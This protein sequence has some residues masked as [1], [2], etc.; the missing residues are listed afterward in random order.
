MVKAGAKLGGSGVL[1]GQVSTS[2]AATISPGESP[3]NM[4]FGG[5]SMLSGTYF[6]ELGALTTAGP[7]TNF[8]LITVNTNASQVGGTSQVLL[9]FNL[10]AP[11]SQPGNGDA[12]WNAPHQ[13][14]IFDVAGTASSTGIFGSIANATFS[15]GNFSLSGGDGDIFLGF[16]PV[17]AAQAP[18]PGAMAMWSLMSLAGLPFCY[19]RYCR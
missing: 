8:D 2:G 15:Q 3:A 5:F 14:L 19:R 1:P 11:A 7:G 4:V 16:T 18:E 12:F 17:A 6:W 10:L 9:D 13:W